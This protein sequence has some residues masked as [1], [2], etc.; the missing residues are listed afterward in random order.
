MGRDR[1]VADLLGLQAREVRSARREV[2]VETARSAADHLL[3]AP[4][5]GAEGAG[6]VWS[7]ELDAALSAGWREGVD[8][9][10]LAARLGMDVASVVTRLKDLST[11]G[12]LRGDGTPTSRGRH[13][14]QANGT[15]P[16][17]AGPTTQTRARAQSQPQP[18]PQGQPQP[19]PREQPAGQGMT[20]S[21]AE[22]ESQ[23][24]PERE[25][26]PAQEISG[27]VLEGVVCP[28]YQYGY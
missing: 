22:W 5:A 21:W 4:A 7:E 12:I 24:T 26:P 28:P 2:G 11:Q 17:P 3:N 15:P 27:L 1:S 9:H 13:R 14:K 25:R 6:T 10:A 18:Q 16:R 19:Q 20:E 8:L 23:L